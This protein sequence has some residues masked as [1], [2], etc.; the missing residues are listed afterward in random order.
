VLHMENSLRGRVA[1]RLRST[2]FSTDATFSSGSSL[3]AR[4][5]MTAHRRRRRA[6]AARFS[7]STAVSGF[8]LIDLYLDRDGADK[9]ATAKADR[10][11]LL[12]LAYF[13]PDELLGHG[14]AS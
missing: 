8:C 9:L 13:P 10:D 3:N 4:F 14:L 5:Q 7:P 6:L 12:R 11:V 2:L 1:L